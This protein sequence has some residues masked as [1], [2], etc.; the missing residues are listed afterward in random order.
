MGNAFADGGKMFQGLGLGVEWNKV[1]NESEVL[2]EGTGRG[3]C[4]CYIVLGVCVN[5]CGYL[6]IGAT[7]IVWSV[8]AYVVDVVD[9]GLNA[10]P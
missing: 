3:L 7:E 8:G 10:K 1:A 5:G 4:G 9:H 2:G 6:E